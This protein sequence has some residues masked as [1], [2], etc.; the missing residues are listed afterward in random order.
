MK[1]TLIVVY[2]FVYGFFYSQSLT[3]SLSACYALN[4]N[5]LDPI[6][7][8]NGTL[9]AVSAT[10]DR[11][12]VG[13]SAFHLSGSSSSYIQ[14]PGNPLLRPTNAL[15]FS[16]WLRFDDMTSH[17]Y[18]L[19][20]GNGCASYFEGY[21]LTVENSGG[22][23]RFALCKADGSCSPGSQAVLFGNAT[24]NALTWYHVGFYMGNDSLKMYVNGVPDGAMPVSFG[25]NYSPP[26]TVYLGGT[27][28][29]SWN[30]PMRGSIDNV[31]FYNRKLSHAEFLTLYTTDPSCASQSV[32]A[33]AV[34]FDGGND[35]VDPNILV[36]AFSNNFTIES[37]VRPT[38]THQI[39]LETT[40]GINGT[41][42]KRFMLWP[43]WRGTD[44]GIGIS[45]G[46]NGVSVYDH[47]NNFIPALL[48]WSGTISGWTHIAVVINNKQP[49]LY[50]NGVLVKTGLTSPRLNVWPSLGEVGQYG[51]LVGGIGG[52]TYGFYQ[53]D[54]DE[55]RI[56][57]SV[58][59]SAQIIAGMNSEFAC[60]PPGLYAYYKF[61]QG[62]AGGNNATVTT[63][64]DFSGNNFTA[65]LTAMALNGPT[66]N[67][68]SPGGTITS[69]L[70]TLSLTTTNTIVCAGQSLTLAVSGASSYTWQPGSFTGSF[71][72][73][74]PSVSTVYT[75]T[76]SGG[77][78]VGS[79]T[80]GVSVISSPS[81]SPGNLNTTICEG[82]G[83]TLSVS[84]A[85]SYSW[86]PLFVTGPVVVVNPSVTT[87]YT[88][89]GSNG[90]CSAS[91][92]FTVHV[93]PKPNL[94]PNVLPASLC[95]GQNATLSANNAQT[96]TW[97]PGNLNNAAVVVSPSVST[98]YTVNGTS[99]FGCQGTATLSLN[100]L[101]VPSLS[102]VANPTGICA[103]G[104]STLTVNGAPGYTW[105]PGNFT[106]NSIVVNPSATTTYTVLG[107]NGS[108]TAAAFVTVTNTLTPVVS[109]SGNLCNNNL[110]S[111]F[112][113][114][115]TPGNTILWSGPGI[116]GPANTASINVNA[117]GIYTV[118]IN[119][120]IANCSGVS[121]IN[122]NSSST[123][124]VINIIPSNTVACYPGPPINMLVSSSSS[125]TWFPANAVNPSTGPLVSVSPTVSSSYTVVGIL[126]SCSGTA[127]IS[128]SVNITP[129]VI[130]SS[131]TN[132]VCLGKTATLSASGA[133]DYN[134]IPGN[135][136]GATVTLVPGA[137]TIYSVIGMNGFCAD[138]SS[139][140][141]SVF[142]SPVIS[143]TVSA[144]SICKGQ[145]VNIQVQAASA[146]TWQPIA[147]NGASIV[148]SPSVNTVYTVSVENSFACVAST[149]VPITVIPVFSLTVSGNSGVLC[150]GQT[151]NLIVS[152]ATTYTWF[153]GALSGSL[154]SVSPNVS[155]TYTVVADALRC[156]AALV[157]VSVV[158]CTSDA[159]G[160]T[161]AAGIPELTNANYYKIDFTVT[162]VNNS[163]EDLLLVDLTTDLNSTFVYPNTFTV[164]KAPNVIS[165]GSG[166]K[167]TSDFDG[168]GQNHLT[169]SP[170]S[171]LY[172][173]R[174][175]TICYSV[176]LDPH[177]FYGPL[178]NFVAGITQPLIGLPLSDLSNDGFEWDPDKDGNPGNNNVI[179]IITIPLIELFIPG[180]F[181]PNGDGI[182]DLFTIS[183]LNGREVKLQV[184]NRWGNKVFEKENYENT[185]DGKANAGGIIAGN[186]KLPQG[187]YFYVLQFKDG[188]KEPIHG[189]IV[190]QY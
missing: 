130:I 89:V 87:V 88:V 141:L 53:G 73:L 43:T 165:K 128:I 37:W 55:F 97:Q 19:Y 56:W 77:A 17:H 139:V 12:N 6:N 179:T 185:W 180:G 112:V 127:V 190:M 171:V 154:I 156:S 51:P 134:W 160:L 164:L 59:S 74:S 34:N 137:T 162:A 22:G 52:G 33:N 145:S 184:F 11:N 99:A 42:G 78:C 166:L 71:V 119:D 146:Y 54:I 61:N 24:L 150:S 49:F 110:V 135:L 187:T 8:L 122:V 80:V 170:S 181:S 188:S 70:S 18:I 90:N 169:F 96:Y 174:R 117:G 66:S 153:P 142:P 107:A 68:I 57:N 163:K 168:M 81:L 50:V 2:L 138:T 109:S 82:A 125:L 101:P 38:A 85:T 158:S 62:I 21:A 47:G 63:A 84:G 183:G 91:T 173:G 58:R 148:V 26:L 176:L 121:T 44:G 149:L 108:C 114:P 40:S 39:D 151:Q 161:N 76:G 36:N 86:F 3:T 10:V 31:R 178:E 9:S 48:A 25:F 116:S 147:S 172:A 93:N 100:V 29:S 143:P 69:T 140:S 5:A 144:S 65:T 167:M 32:S 98:V 27:T 4:G 133:T 104:S 13:T 75:V 152:G 120:P 131:P 182:N 175:D 7:G 28:I 102:A 186:N 136:A 35:F 45:V 94:S 189:F 60:P 41:S 124:L 79:V 64:T 72:V 115:N 126:G 111:L 95:A 103:G 159:F 67:W 14:L 113:S 46:T 129:T 30:Y 118:V 92:N 155:T 132:T 16:A 123:P 15:S 1:Q 20:T 177:G 106:G 23:Y 105:Y 83:S 157:P